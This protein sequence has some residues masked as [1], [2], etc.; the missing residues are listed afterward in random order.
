MVSITCPVVC[1]RVSRKE[2]R[3]SPR[4]SLCCLCNVL[5]EVTSWWYWLASYM[6]LPRNSMQIYWSQDHSK[7]N[8]GHGQC[9]WWS[10]GSE[11]WLAGVLDSS[12]SGCMLNTGYRPL[13]LFHVIDLSFSY[14][15]NNKGVCWLFRITF[16]SI[17]LVGKK[18]KDIF[19]NFFHLVYR[20]LKKILVSLG[21][22]V[23]YVQGIQVSWIFW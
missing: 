15:L 2:K 5:G 17:C 13:N 6:L 19:H 23:D 4:V 11:V 8:K 21:N 7:Q 22:Q 16:I 20:H 18:K 12:L 14:A 1:L 10:S 9:F 3:T